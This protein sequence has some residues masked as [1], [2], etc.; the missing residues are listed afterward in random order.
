VFF[1]DHS[2]LADFMGVIPT[3]SIERICDDNQ[4]NAGLCH[5][6]A[7]GHYSRLPTPTDQCAPC[8]P[9]GNSV[10]KSFSLPATFFVGRTSF[11]LTE[12]VGRFRI[13]SPNE[14]VGGVPSAGV[15]ATRL[16]GGRLG[17]QGPDVSGCRL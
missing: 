11:R 15:S 4:M 6:F 13:E 14:A 1:D 12:T 5:T 16:G 2:T 3:I 7:L 10:S 17:G 8:L 9:R